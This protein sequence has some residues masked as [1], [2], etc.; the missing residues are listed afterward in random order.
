[1]R[2]TASTSTV[3]LVNSTVSS[4]ARDLRMEPRSMEFITYALASVRGCNPAMWVAISIS[5]LSLPSVTAWWRKGKLT[6][7]KC[8]PNWLP[9]IE[10][11]WESFPEAQMK[12]PWGTGTY[13]QAGTL[14]RQGISKASA[15]WQYIY[16]LL[17]WF[18]GQFYPVPW[19][20]HL[21]TALPF[22]LAFPSLFFQGKNSFHF[23]YQSKIVC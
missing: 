15:N 4:T 2:N 19:L 11:P 12:A 14:P 9:S 13:G 17:L 21:L 6:N 22:S 5:G 3:P 8:Y 1:M 20:L 23:A 10:S 7:L 18:F 16:R